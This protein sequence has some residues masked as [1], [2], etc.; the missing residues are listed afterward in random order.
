MKRSMKKFVLLCAILIFA[1]AL[2]SAQGFYADVGLGFEFGFG[3]VSYANGARLGYGPFGN[4]PMYAAVDLSSN[5]PIKIQ[6]GIII[7]PVSFLQLGA[8]LG[9]QLIPSFFLPSKAFATPFV[10]CF[11][12]TISAAADLGMAG[13]RHGALIGLQYSGA[14]YEGSSKEMFL[15]SVDIFS[16]IGIFARYTYRIK[17]PQQQ[18][19]NPQQRE[20]QGGTAEPGTLT[21]TD[22]PEEFNGKFASS[23]S[24]W[25]IPDY[26]SR[27]PSSRNVAG[28]ESSIIIN[29]EVKMPII[30]PRAFGKPNGYVGSDILDV[31]FDIGD[32]RDDWQARILY[33][34]FQKVQFENG[35]AEVNWEDRIKPGLITVT[36]IPKEYNINEQYKDGYNKSSGRAEIRIGQTTRVVADSPPAGI[37]N[38]RGTVRNGTITVGVLRN[39]DETGFESFPES[40]TSNILLVLH[41]PAPVG[42]TISIIQTDQF[43]FRNVQIIDGKATLNFNRGV[44]QQ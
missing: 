24:M 3:T 18:G 36:N 26:T 42:K 6:P 23:N 28:G 34:V 39:R 30:V 19:V 21:I 32:T 12:W 2:V 11:G 40:T 15:H 8:S 9:L 29:G 44:R 27:F 25:S 37:P 20:R 31:H 38:G 7:Y 33:G 43:L 10:P 1:S 5:F 14:A 13:S 16:S 17:D 41:L 4:E 35:V 22:I